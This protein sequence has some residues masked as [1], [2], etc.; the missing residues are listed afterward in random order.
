MSKNKH[1]QCKLCNLGVG[2]VEL[3]PT[4]ASKK[5]GISRASV[6]RHNEH[7]SPKT[8]LGVVAPP[9]VVSKHRASSS[10]ELANSPEHA[11]GIV[12]SRSDSE[13]EAQQA[14]GEIVV[15]HSSKITSVP[16]LSKDP[17]V[18]RIVQEGKDAIRNYRPKYTR[19]EKVNKTHVGKI[20]ALADA[21]LGKGYQRAGGSDSTLEL[22]NKAAH[23]FL[24]ELKETRPDEATILD[25]GD[26]IEG[27]FNFNGQRE[28]NDLDLVSQLDLAFNYLLNLVV[29]AAHYVRKLYV[30]SVPSNHCE[31]RAGKKDQIGSSD[32]DYGL[33]LNKMVERV[34]DEGND[35]IEFI[36]PENHYLQAEWEMAGT[37]L[38]V[39]HGHNLSN[40]NAHAKWW[41]DQAFNKRPGWD[42]DI[43]F[44]GHYHTPRL[45]EVDR[46]RWIIHC[47]TCESGSDKFEN[48][49]GSSG[50]RGIMT[51]DVYN[52]KWDNYRII[53][54]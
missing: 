32:N 12:L 4:A 17:V 30:V 15:L 13:W 5:Y 52:G 18:E 40:I 1:P 3:T 7:A 38:A 22:M 34:F 26:I 39:F 44:T 6:R 20:F 36:R 45:E 2:Y 42:A 28:Q 53:T 31:I 24:K 8:L 50:T 10:A 11:G 27:F 41:K 54:L 51:L 43:L 9:Q 35:N 25:V 49:S 33:L 48:V 37:K 19:E 29:K 21:Q 23:I 46:G 47:P 14:G 16:D